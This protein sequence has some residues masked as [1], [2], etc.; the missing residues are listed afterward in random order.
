[1]NTLPRERRGDYDVI[2]SKLMVQH[3][4]A[5]LGQKG[6]RLANDNASSLVLTFLGGHFIRK[7]GCVSVRIAEKAMEQNLPITCEYRFVDAGR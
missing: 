3:P 1:M 4:N 5:E 7:G 2:E 6:D